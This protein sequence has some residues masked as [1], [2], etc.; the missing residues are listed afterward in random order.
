MMDKYESLKLDWQVMGFRKLQ[1]SDASFDLAVDKGTS[2]AVLHG[3]LWDPEEDVK[4]NAKAY[5]DI[6][7]RVLKPGGK[8]LHFTYRQTHSLKL[9]LQ[10]PNKWDIQ[11]ETLE[12][13]PGIFEYF[14]S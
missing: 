6:V 4:V 5:V 8:L 1:V 11:V 7:A 9:I 10:K 14:G 13:A 3:S 12:D 2:D